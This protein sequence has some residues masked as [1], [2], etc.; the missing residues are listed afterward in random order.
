MLAIDC[1]D[2]HDP[3]R[4]RKTEGGHRRGLT[5]HIGH[6]HTVFAGLL[7]GG[8]Q[9]YNTQ[10]RRKENMSLTDWWERFVLQPL[11]SKAQSVVQKV[12]EWETQ[13]SSGNRGPR[14]RLFVVFFCNWGRHRSVALQKA[15]AFVCQQMKWA[16]LAETSHLSSHSWTF[17][18][19]DCCQVHG[20]RIVYPQSLETCSW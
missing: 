15:F 20:F 12:R 18:T 8:A 13:R 19:C 7:R 3:Q 5:N 14:P 9:V 11:W 4:H 2:F 10:T 6:H 17:S 16:H 1:R